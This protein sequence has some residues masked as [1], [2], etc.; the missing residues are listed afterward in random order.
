MD[1]GIAWNAKTKEG[2]WTVGEEVQVTLNLEF[3]KQ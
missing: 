3:I 2:T 1:Y